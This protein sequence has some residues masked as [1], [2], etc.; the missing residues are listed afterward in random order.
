MSQSFNA[1]IADITIANGGTTS[2]GVRGVYEYDDA[3]CI[4]IQAPA[5]MTNATVIEVSQDD[6]TYAVL[7]DGTS[8]IAGPAAGKSRQYTEMLGHK[9][10]RLVSAGNEGALRTFKVTKRWTV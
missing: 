4:T 3:T 10:W 5:A 1:G 7:N 8:D 9:Y 6:V 2:R